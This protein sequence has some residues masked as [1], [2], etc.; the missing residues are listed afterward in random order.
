MMNS[1]EFERADDRVRI[2]Q[3]P[4]NGRPTLILQTP[5]HHVTL[6]FGR[7]LERYEFQ[8][9]FEHHLLVSGWHLVGFSRRRL[10]ASGE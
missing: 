8:T 6:E 7:K 3:G 5:T 2:C 1:W 4:I 10:V 9:A